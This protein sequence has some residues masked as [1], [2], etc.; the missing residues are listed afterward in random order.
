MTTLCWN[1]RG[2][3]NPRTIQF[4]KDLII[5]KKPK[6]VF[7]CE[8]FSKRDKVEHLRS[9]LA[10]EGCFVVDAQGHSGGL[11]MLWKFEKEGSVLSFSQS[12]I[13]LQ[14]QV[15]NFPSFRLTG[16]YG[17]PNRSRRHLS[18]SKIRSLAGVSN[19]P[20]CLFGDLNNTLSH[21][22][23]KGGPPYP[24]WLVKGF[25][26]AISAS[27][28]LELDLE[29]HQFTWEKGRG[30][31][32]W[33]EIRLD[34][35]FVTP[36]WR[37]IFPSARLFNLGF[38]SSDHSPLLLTFVS[39][40]APRSKQRFRFENAW[41]REPICRQLIQSYWQSRE[42]DSILQKLSNCRSVLSDWGKEVTGK[43][44]LRLNNCK[45]EINQI[46]NSRAESDIL[47]YEELNNQFFHILMQRELY[48]K[49]RAKQ[50]WLQGGD[51][52]TRFFHSWA[53]KHR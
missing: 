22:D 3:G 13:D 27:N 4:L 33:V 18:W 25:H 34:R 7:L 47:R 23:K 5:Q 37:S 42:S 16:F 28:L 10:F 12:H 35:A 14:I 24:N 11:A 1:C 39:P 41:T 15:E 17:E 30:S 44:K 46:R 45:S 43:F 8:T 36:S 40:I 29:G 2:L 26:S 32:D 51:N 20:W 9:L 48:W 38:S 53:S 6:F 50:L 31:S 21:C 19:L 52:N 49:Q